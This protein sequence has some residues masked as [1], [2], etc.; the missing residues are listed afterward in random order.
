MVCGV[1]C[2]GSRV[3]GLGSRLSGLG[4]RVSGFRSRVSGLESRVSGFGFRVSGFGFRVSSLHVAGDRGSRGGDHKS[5]LQDTSLVQRSGFRVWGL[6]SRVQCSQFRVQGSV[7]R[8]QGAGFR[9]QGSG[10]RVQGSGCRV[11][12]SGL[13]VQG[14]GFRVQGRPPISQPTPCILHSQENGLERVP[15]VA[16]GQQ[17]LAV[18][19]TTL[20][21]ERWTTT[22]SS[23]V[24]L[25][26]TI[27][28]RALRSANLVTLRSKFRTN[29]TL[30]VHH[31]VP[32][33]LFWVEGGAA[34]K[35]ISLSVSQSWRKASR[36][37][38][39]SACE[40]GTI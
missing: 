28:F 8:V 21:P 11:Q 24:N 14:L 3:S 22:L 32:L 5:F 33:P 6:G 36:V 39:S 38:R 23:K 17:S 35:I 10:F 26:Y 7:F 16:E 40:K 20:S 18:C 31:A 19:P 29:E 13:R 4:R 27:N 2:F 25:P 15:V 37:S 30:E 9:V 34:H 1:S 12:G